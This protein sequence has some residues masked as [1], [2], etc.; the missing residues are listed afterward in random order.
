MENNPPP[1]PPQKTKQQQQNTLP[2]LHS[3]LCMILNL[4]IFRDAQ[5]KLCKTHPKMSLHRAKQL[6]LSYFQVEGSPKEKETYGPGVKDYF[7][8][9]CRFV[10]SIAKADTNPDAVSWIYLTLYFVY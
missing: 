4:W 8:L 7:W 9:A 1:P 2:T 10:E 6:L 5:L 3:L